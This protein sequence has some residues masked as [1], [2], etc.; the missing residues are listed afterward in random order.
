LT[1]DFFFN[2]RGFIESYS[3]RPKEVLGSV[4]VTNGVKIEAVGQYIHAFSVFEEPHPQYFFS[5][6][7]RISGPPASIEEQKNLEENKDEVP[8]ETEQFYPC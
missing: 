1:S 5:Y 8:N 6:Q 2:K 7:I 3:S 4:T